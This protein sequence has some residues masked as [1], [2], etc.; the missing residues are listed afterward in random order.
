VGRLDCLLTSTFVQQADTSQALSSARSVLPNE[1]EVKSEVKELASHQP[2]SSSEPLEGAAQLTLAP[3]SHAQDAKAETPTSKKV[4]NDPQEA[5]YDNPDVASAAQPLVSGDDRALMQDQ[6]AVVA[7][8]RSLDTSERETSAQASPV[9][10]SDKDEK[11]NAESS[12]CNTVVSTA[13]SVL[14]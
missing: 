6:A 12:T 1:H 14:R 10:Q 4:E 13:G 11:L 7:A 3:Q 5:V 8:S 2:P 9:N